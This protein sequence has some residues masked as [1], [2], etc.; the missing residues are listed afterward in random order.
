MNKHNPFIYRFRFTS[1][2]ARVIPKTTFWGEVHH[3]GQ[4]QHYAGRWSSTQIPA[5]HF[6][7]VRQVI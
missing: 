2:N 5:L 1:Q 6:L 7:A 4:H 3:R